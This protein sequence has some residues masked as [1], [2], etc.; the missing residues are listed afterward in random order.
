MSL[1]QFE[2]LKQTKQKLKQQKRWLLHWLLM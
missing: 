1:L 2:M